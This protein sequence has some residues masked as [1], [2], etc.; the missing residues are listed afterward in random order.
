MKTGKTG[1]DYGIYP[2]EHIATPA[3]SGADLRY[4]PVE[5]WQLYWKFKEGTPSYTV[6]KWWHVSMAIYGNHSSPYGRARVDVVPVSQ[7]IIT[8]TSRL[9]VYQIV[10]RTH[11]ETIK[12]KFGFEPELFEIT[13]T[14]VFFKNTK[15]V[16]SYWQVEY[17]K[18]EYGPVD[19]VFRRMTDFDIDQKF[20]EYQDE[21][22]TVFYP[23][24]KNDSW[25]IGTDYDGEYHGYAQ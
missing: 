9:L 22:F 18:T 16:A 20:Q 2:S 4:Y 14:L 13:G 23:N 21:A 19:V 12:T 10:L 15:K 11:N 8:N 7:T 5:G 1:A 25:N 3:R 6:D 24:S 17:L